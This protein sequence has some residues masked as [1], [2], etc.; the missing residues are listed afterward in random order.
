MMEMIDWNNVL[1]WGDEILF[2]LFAISIAYLFIFAIFSLKEERSKYKF[3]QTDYKYSLFLI[4]NG[5]DQSILKSVESINAQEFPKGNFDTYVLW[6]KADSEIIATLEGL[7]V[8]T[9]KVSDEYFKKGKM[10]EFALEQCTRKYDAAVILKSGNTIEKDFLREINNAYHSGGMAIQTHRISVGHKSNTGILNALGEE[11]NNAIYRRGHVNLG[12]SSSLL[13]SGMVFNFDWLRQNIGRTSGHSLT[14]QLESMLHRQGIFIEY[15]EN[16]HVMEEKANRLNE[17]DK[18]RRYWYSAE[19]KTARKSLIYFPR[20]LLSGNFDFCDKIIQW[21]M[22]SKYVLLILTASISGLLLWWDWSLS[23]KW[24]ILL[25]TL[26]L[27]ILLAIPARFMNFRTTLS[28][29]SLPLLALSILKNIFRR[30][31]S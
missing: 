18:Q 3:S 16:V 30:G 10:I 13:G 27:S 7:G 14:K 25:F 17:F 2:L 20:A 19:R 21:L 9:I 15:L 6:N 26:V 12:F 31:K 22:P 23:L 8:L 28:L 1:T 11:I 29:I 24:W 5:N 4:L